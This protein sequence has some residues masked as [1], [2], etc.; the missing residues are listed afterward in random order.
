MPW[1]FNFYLV[2]M[3]VMAG[4][5]SAFAMLVSESRAPSSAMNVGVFD[6]PVEETS[7]SLFHAFAPENMQVLTGLNHDV[8]FDKKITGVLKGAWRGI[9]NF[10]PHHGLHGWGGTKVGDLHLGFTV[11]AIKPLG[12]QADIGAHLLASSLA[13][14]SHKFARGE[15]QKKSTNCQNDGDAHECDRR[16]RIN[17]I[18][19]P[20]DGIDQSPNVRHPFP[21]KPALGGLFMAA[22]LF[23]FGVPVAWFLNR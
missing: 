7:L 9:D 22:A 12:A 19:G 20:V 16:G 8:L 21:R 17:V 13:G 11:S 15:P 3:L 23:L 6:V 1:L 14:N 2:V 5:P 18:G 4:I 10:T